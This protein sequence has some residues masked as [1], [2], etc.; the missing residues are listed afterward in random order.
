MKLI[1]AADIHLD[2]PM[3][4]L[5]RH[6]GAPVDELRGAT[7]K[8]LANLVDLAIDEQVAAVLLAGDLFDGDWPH[9]GTGVHFV[10]EMGRLREAGIQVVS[11]AGNHDAESKL[12]KSLKMPDNF[13]ELGTKKP[14]TKVFEALGLA[15]HG[16]GYA[17]PAVTDDLSTAY[18][19]AL[20]DYLNVGLLHTC[21]TG[22][23]GHEHYAPCKVEALA[24]RG[25]GYWGLGHVHAYEVL[26]DD[27]PVIFSGVL[28][29]RGMREAGPKGAVLLEATTDRVTSFE[30]RPLDVVRWQ[31]LELNAEGI[32]S[33]DEACELARLS[34]RE[35]VGV[36]DGRLLAA[37]VVIAGEC[38]AHQQLLADPE[39]LHAEMMAAAADVG[40]DQVWVEK[41][42]LETQPARPSAREGADAVGELLREL[43][44]IASDPEALADVG[45]ELAPLAGVLP[46]AMRD[47]WDPTSPDVV[48]Q[49][50]AELSA[51]L[52]VALLE[53]EGA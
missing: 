16:Q 6:E 46:S 9:Y 14:E 11:I 20:D 10:K 52:P 51:S 47:E 35:A 45:R 42:K 31:V 18:P 25:Y 33:L 17:M 40:G 28:Q 4:G 39:R 37:R 34:L 13:F 41:V 22:R 53:G 36:A 8:A 15:V 19:S 50:L 1:A 48:R 26:N 7:R 32:A 30:L 5:A 38:E 21:V 49:V 24:H 29:G 23:P 27:P 43:D 2:S 12:T 44:E 3:R